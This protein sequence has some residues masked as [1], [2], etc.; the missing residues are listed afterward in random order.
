MNAIFAY[1]FIF[2]ALALLLKSPELFLST[3]LNGAQ[4]ASALCLAL[5]SSYALWLGLISVWEKCG[6]N[7]KISRFFKPFLRKLFKTD[8]DGALTA[9]SMNLSV[10]LLGIGGAAT[11]YGVQASKLLDKTEN[12]E[13]SSTLLFVINATS[14]QLIPTAIVGVRASLGAIS[15][16]DIIFPSLLATILSTLLGVFLTKA[17]FFF[18]TKFSLRTSKETRR[19]NYARQMKAGTQ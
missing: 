2:G 18:K 8:D 7:E 11:P 17:F 12:A 6:I 16:S 14:V 4:K 13:Y 9:I 1:L 5:L 3:L 10:N 15:P 19:K